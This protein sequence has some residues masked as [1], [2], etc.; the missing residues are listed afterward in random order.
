M[1]FSAPIFLFYFLPAVLLLVFAAAKSIKL[2]NAVL[3]IASLFFYAWGEAF[4]LL[5]L[6]TSISMNYLFGL[7]LNSESCFARRSVFIAALTANLG[8]LGHYKYSGFLIE[9]VNVLLR[10]L[11]IEAI[12]YEPTHL[13]LGISFF[14]FQAI[15]YLVDVYT[16][17][18]KAQRNPFHL[19]LFISLFPQLIAGPIIRY[20]DLNRQI[21][22]RTIT[23]AGIDSGVRLFIIGL[24]KKV[25][26]ADQLGEV[27]DLIFS[28]NPDTVGLGLAW[29]GAISFALQI[30][31]DFSGYSDMAIGMGRI[32]GFQFKPNFNY[33]YIAQS[34][35]DFWQRWHISLTSL[36]RDYI[37]TPLAARQ[38]R[39]KRGMHFVLPLLFTMLI[40]GFWHGAA[41]TFI[42]FGLFHGIMLLTE[43]VFKLQTRIPQPV[44]HGYVLL[45]WV[46]GCVLFRAEDMSQ[47]STLIT[48]MAGFNAPSDPFTVPSDPL[49]YFTFLAA[50]LASTPLFPLSFEEMRASGTR[51]KIRLAYLLRDAGLLTLFLLSLMAIATGTVDNFIY[52]RF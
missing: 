39:K 34:L 2:Q 11:N 13:P 21:I 48:V 25:L 9:N 37:Y 15:T 46:I 33:P 27:S 40:L 35:S 44:R 5:L 38:A 6:L 26:I 17:R 18:T 36:A 4:Y 45:I 52:F 14:T 28:L 24:A 41:W 20:H 47:A 10:T 1:V 49:L 43:Q 31:F 51:W 42:V 8:I 19:A 3:L 32:F 50:C 23:L 7:L 22:D 16:G 12:I 30:Y 29:L